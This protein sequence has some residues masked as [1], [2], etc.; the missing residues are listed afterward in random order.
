[1]ERWGRLGEGVLLADGSGYMG[2]LNVFHEL[3]CIVSRLSLQII[4]Q[5]NEFP[6]AIVHV[7]VP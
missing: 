5:V 1:M 6:G 2:T 7:D 4:L 3:H